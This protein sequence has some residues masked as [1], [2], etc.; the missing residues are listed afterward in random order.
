[1]YLGAGELHS[2]LEGVGIEIMGNSDN[3]LRGGL[4]AKH[5]DVSELC[6]VLC[7]EPREP[8][9]LLP[10]EI[11]TGERIFETPAAE[12]EL[13]ALSVKKDKPW[14]SASSRGVE[15]LL[16]IEGEMT[17]TDRGVGESFAMA[18]GASV[19]VPNSVE[20]YELAGA[21]VV[22]RAGVPKS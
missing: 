2:Y 21:G 12:F 8:E 22:Y 4:T 17:I 18:R 3:V 10:R 11:S 20:C 16:A 9:I 13:A 1:M 15:I 5:V 19:L 14:R 6:R 7:F